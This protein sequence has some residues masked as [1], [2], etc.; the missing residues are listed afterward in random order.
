MSAVDE[1][2]TIAKGAAVAWS[3]PLAADSVT[4]GNCGL[5]VPDRRG[6]FSSGGADF[7]QAEQAGLA[8]ALA[9][10]LAGRHQEKRRLLIS[11]RLRPRAHAKSLT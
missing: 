6:S 2:V 11:G 5:R 1:I 3:A 9:L 10:A 8:L 7:A 4:T